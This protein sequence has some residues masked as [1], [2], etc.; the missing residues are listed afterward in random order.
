MSMIE[1]CVSETNHYLPLMDTDIITP[2][3]VIGVWGIAM[4]D[5]CTTSCID[6]LLNG[7]SL[8]DKTT[9]LGINR[10]AVQ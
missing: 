2:Y 5:P 7:F 9:S 10:L 4:L 1:T 3:R 8:E 6:G